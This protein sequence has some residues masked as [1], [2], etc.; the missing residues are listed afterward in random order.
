[1][2]A[3]AGL[4]LKSATLLKGGY[5]CLKG[6]RYFDPAFFLRVHFPIWTMSVYLLLSGAWKQTVLCTTL[7]CTPRYARRTFLLQ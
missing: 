3:E 2:A 5:C 6:A 7:P 4:L 1:M